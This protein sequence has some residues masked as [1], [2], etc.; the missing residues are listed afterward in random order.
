[1][2]NFMAGRASQAG[3]VIKAGI[4][5]LYIFKPT[6]LAPPLFPSQSHSPVLMH[7]EV[8]VFPSVKVMPT[9]VSK[10]STYKH[11]D[12]KRPIER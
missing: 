2:H 9:K 6:F 1:M 5:T 4:C 7:F 12:T 3:D 11:G 10:W 8:A